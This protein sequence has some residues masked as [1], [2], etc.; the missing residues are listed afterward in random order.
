MSENLLDTILVQLNTTGL[1][2][3]DPR[4][5]Q[6]LK[7]LIGGTIQVKDSVTVVSSSASSALTGSGTTGL[8]S[9]WATSTSLTDV[10]AAGISAALDLL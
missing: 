10:S 7:S 2:K 1:A 8:I 3:K 4:L 6:V 5:Y 9:Q